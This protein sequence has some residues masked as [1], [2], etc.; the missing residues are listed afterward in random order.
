MVKEIVDDAK[1][2]MDKS[3][4]VLQKE[5][6][7]IRTGRASLAIFDNVRVDYYGSPTP[8]NQVANL[9]VPEA[10]LIT[11]QPWEPPM[12]E[13]IEK[14]ILS[15]DLDLNPANDGKILRIPIP[16]LTEERRKL[17]VKQVGKLAEESRTAIRQVRRDVNDRLKKLLKDKEISEDEERR[18]LKEVQD[19]T[20][21]HVK[22]VD[23]V[24][25]KKD[26][27]LMTI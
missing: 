19:L 3:M 18:A 9:A 13:K 5:L 6:A 21:A 12:L 4:E 15:S 22:K 23:E 1:R 20:D 8:L 24:V 25:K 2:R 7:S 27:E 26:Q 16:P 17:L 11:I 10:N 14:A